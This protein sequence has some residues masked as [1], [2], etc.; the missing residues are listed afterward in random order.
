MKITVVA[1]LLV[2]AFASAPARA[3]APAQPGGTTQGE[4]NPDS[5]QPPATG[6]S[7]SSQ[8][9]VVN[10]P[11]AQQQP[12]QQQPAPQQPA[13]QQPPPP[14]PPSPGSTTVVN[15]PPPSTTVVTPTREEEARRRRSP[16]AIVALD[17]LYGGVAGLLVG[18]G[19]ALINEGDDWQEALMIGAGAGI[20]VGTAV[21]VV[22]AY[23]ENSDEADARRTA[24]D[25]QGST[26]RDP[27][28]T[29]RPVIAIGGRF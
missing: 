11:P 6:T 20:L 2:L 22:H 24:F 17:A 23:S 28:I 29:T 18:G 19:V 9:V 3:Q 1:T 5:T 10:P 4:T 21:G 12:A 16:M 15:P 14:Q 26:V 7:G 27:V 13:P 25:G 8:Q